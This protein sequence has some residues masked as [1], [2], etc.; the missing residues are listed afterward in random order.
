MVETLSVN[1]L[2]CE[3]LPPI[4]ANFRRSHPGIV[5]ELSLSNRNED[6]L[7]RHADIAVRMARPTQV[8]LIARRI[9][10]VELR[11]Y[12]HKDYAA[13]FGLPQTEAD[14]AGHC[15][16]GFD[17]DDHAVRSLGP[18]TR[19][20]TRE[21][22]G[23]RTDGDSAQLAALR[24]GVG[25]AGCQVRIAEHSPDLLPVLHKSV[26]FS[27]EMWLLMHESLKGTRRVR[28]LFDHLAMELSAY[29]KG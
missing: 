24:A 27:L 2:G 28:L 12:A 8:A 3:V 25:I 6:L 26:A 16:I 1:P 18:A 23:Y 9:G 13:R 5:L 20:I 14:M 10:A 15:L 11:L 4:L 7:R 19:S 17:R 22:F 21:S 29:V